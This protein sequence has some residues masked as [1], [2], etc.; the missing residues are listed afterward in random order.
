MDDSFD[1]V[2]EIKGLLRDLSGVPDQV[3][4][5]DTRPLSPRFGYVQAATISE[6]RK[7]LARML[8]M[9]H[10]FRVA[11]PGRCET[12]DDFDSLFGGRMLLAW[13]ALAAINGRE[14]TAQ[15]MPIPEANY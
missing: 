10:A 9:V 4:V 13:G 1:H 8:E 11:H 7:D 6:L 5:E 15:L 14:S 3:V 2:A 12:A